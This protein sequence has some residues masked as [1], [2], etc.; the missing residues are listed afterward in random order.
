MFPPATLSRPVSPITILFLYIRPARFFLRLCYRACDVCGWKGG[1]KKEMRVEIQLAEKAG[2][3]HGPRIF[4]PFPASNFKPLTPAPKVRH[5]A[6]IATS[7]LTENKQKRICYP[8]THFA[9]RVSPKSETAAKVFHS[10]ISR[11]SPAAA[12]SQCQRFLGGRFSSDNSGTQMKGLQPPRKHS[13]LPHYRAD[14]PAGRVNQLHRQLY[15]NKHRRT[16]R[17]GRESRLSQ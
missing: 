5:A 17:P 14:H 15:E 8:E 10:R 16:C 7:H 1:L 4:P 12:R 6:R 2:S 13:C 11:N 3:G 9:L